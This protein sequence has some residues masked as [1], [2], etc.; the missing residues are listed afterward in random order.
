MVSSVITVHPCV[1]WCPVPFAFTGS[2]A[3][4]LIEEFDLSLNC[5][6][7]LLVTDALPPEGDA[8]KRIAAV[9]NKVD[10]RGITPETADEV[11]NMLRGGSNCEKLADV[12]STVPQRNI[13]MNILVVPVSREADVDTGPGGAWVTVTGSV[14]VDDDILSADRIQD[15][16]NMLPGRSGLLRGPI[17]RVAKTRSLLLCLEAKVTE[18][19]YLHNA[20]NAT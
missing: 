7:E 8:P 2:S 3:M 6:D 4:R 20:V 10:M 5:S 16:L 17:F 15:A 14:R 13:D 18:H 12:V 19:G 1:P 9:G 11:I